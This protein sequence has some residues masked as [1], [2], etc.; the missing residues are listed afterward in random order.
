MIRRFTVLRRAI[1]SASSGEGRP[2]GGAAPARHAA[3][4]RDGK[5]AEADSANAALFEHLRP[6]PNGLLGERDG[7]N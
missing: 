1:A 2:V 7:K 5:S 6:R 4:K 3:S